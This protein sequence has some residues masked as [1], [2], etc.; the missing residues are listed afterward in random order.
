MNPYLNSET[1]KSVSKLYSK[2]YSDP[3]KC[4]FMAGINP[5]RIGGGVTGIAFTDPINLQ[6]HCGINNN[7]DK[8]GELSSRFIYNMISYYGGTEMFF[9]IFF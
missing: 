7:F 8:K 9:K 3:G 4:V 1:I 5:G 2:F 6:E